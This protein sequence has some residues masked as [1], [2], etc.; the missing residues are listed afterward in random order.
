MQYRIARN[1]RCFIIG[2]TAVLLL[3][4][5]ACSSADEPT[6][7]STP[8]TQGR[9]GTLNQPNP[10][11]GLDVLPSPARVPQD[12]CQS[13]ELIVAEQASPA[14]NGFGSK[15][16]SFRL[17][18]GSRV[19]IKL[20]GNA[21]SFVL[22][23]GQPVMPRQSSSHHGASGEFTLALGAGSHNVEVSSFDD[24]SIGL[25][26]RADKIR[27]GQTVVKGQNGIIELTNVAV[28]HPMFSPNGDGYHDTALFNADNFPW[29]LPG[30]YS[31]HFDYFLNWEWEVIDAST[32]K[33][34]G[35]VLAGQTQVNSPTNVQALWDGSGAGAANVQALGGTT[36][37]ASPVEDGRYIY[38]YRADL[39]RSDGLWIDTV[40]S[41]PHGFL[42]DSTSSRW[43]NAFATTDS[44]P[45]S[46]GHISSP[47]SVRTCD[48]RN[49]QHDCLCPE[50]SLGSNTRCTFA[51]TEDLYTFENPVD[52]PTSEFITTTIDQ[53]TGRY[54]VEVDLRE[55]NGGGLIPQTDGQFASI[56]ALQEYISALTDVP[57]DT[58][59]NRLFN[60]DYVQ[61][62]YSTPMSGE[63]AVPGF[64]HFLLDVITDASGKISIGDTIYDLPQIFADGESN[65]PAE[66]AIS[67]DRDGDECYHNGNTDGTTEVEGRTCTELRMV[68]LDP[69][70]SNLGIYRI[71]TQIFG[72][73]VDGETTV[74]ESHCASHSCGVRTIQRDAQRIE[75]KRTHY[76]DDNGQL[77]VG[78]INGTVRTDTPALIIETDRFFEGSGGNDSQDGVCSRANLGRNNMEVPLDS[79]DGALPSTCIINGII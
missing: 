58:N 78:P 40:V 2:G 12:P 33:S 64:N 75:V 68:N 73:T 53:E 52:V 70:E 79:A 15:E 71:K 25:E 51:W 36:N 6:S 30:E 59:G 20:T 72:V 44:G 54:T 4:L 3:L 19:C 66:Y 16:T 1:A 67:N 23:N 35:V 37:A 46:T 10:V 50:D 61:L 8:S 74:R 11:C 27:P 47:D 65:I 18:A 22:V 42:V 76:L 17:E 21:M 26:V 41:N 38:Q 55:F 29:Y 43:P 57:A 49:D 62:G 63:G 13:G 7:P 31:G 32:C 28:D 45:A 24:A 34:K 5:G 9:S 14:A 69:G 77:S 39:V 60:F 56:E 48:P